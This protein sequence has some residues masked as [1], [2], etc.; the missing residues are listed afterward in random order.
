MKEVIE[1]LKKNNY[2][3]NIISSNSEDIIKEVLKKNG[4]DVFNKIHSSKNLLENI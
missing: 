2:N 1:T 3:I 4:I